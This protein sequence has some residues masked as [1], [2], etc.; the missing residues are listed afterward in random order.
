[1]FE[2]INNI[3]QR[4]LIKR[5]ARADDAMDCLFLEIAPKRIRWNARIAKAKKMFRVLR[6]IAIS[7]LGIA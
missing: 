2:Y 1:M 3:R 6:W 7:A 4:Q 5:L